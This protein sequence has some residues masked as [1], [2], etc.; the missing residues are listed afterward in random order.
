MKME[1]VNSRVKVVDCEL[2]DVA[3]LDHEWIDCSV[4]QLVRIFYSCG[5]CRE[6]ERNFL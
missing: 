1:G 4:D 3:F 2:D 5:E 6:E